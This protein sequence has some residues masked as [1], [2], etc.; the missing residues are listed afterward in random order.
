M[1]FLRHEF[2]D[3]ETKAGRAHLGG[4][5][6]MSDNIC[7]LGNTHV[8]CKDQSCHGCTNPLEICIVINVCNQLLQ[9]KSNTRRKKM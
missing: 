9:C 7:A 3:P 8:E 1:R 6:S 2:Y 5:K 4:M